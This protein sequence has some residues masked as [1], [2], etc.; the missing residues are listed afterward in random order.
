MNDRK[1]FAVVGGDLRQAYLAGRLTGH[2]RV[3][4]LFFDRDV[5]LSPRVEATS[6]LAALAQGDVVIFPLPI[7]CDNKTLNAPFGQREVSLE[8]C[9]R[10]VRP[11]ALVLGGRVTAPV[12]ALA[13][14]LGIAMED[15]LEREELAV[16]NAVPTAEGAIAIAM[17]ELPITISNCRCL[18][19][20]YGRVA[21][22]LAKDLLGLGAKVTIAARKH[23][24]LAWCQVTGCQAVHIS[25]LGEAVC[26]ADVIFNTVPAM[27]FDEAILSGVSKTCL[28]VDLASKPGGVD[29]ETAK[30]LGLKTVWALSLP[31]KVAPITAGE[32]IKDTVLNIV[33]E[34]G[35]HL[36]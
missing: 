8:A 12:A 21:K 36:G 22:A 30:N 34:R 26:Q 27:I 9:L 19:T 15:Y 33:A 23:A 25:G 3:L 14:E 18:I 31:G 4:G 6:D 2:G 5:E 16:F 13:Q 32:I 24:D 28:V 29:F 7:S 1:T 17:E 11:G 20:G 35:N 10:A